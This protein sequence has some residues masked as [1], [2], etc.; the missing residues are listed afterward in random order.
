[1]GAAVGEATCSRCRVSMM[2]H[3]I[4]VLIERQLGNSKPL[5]VQGHRPSEGSEGLST[6]AQ[7]LLKKII[8]PCR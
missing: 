6:T 8:T 1:M 7:V 4:G 3:R 5:L 2:Y